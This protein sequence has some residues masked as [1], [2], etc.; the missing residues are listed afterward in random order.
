MDP[1]A[2]SSGVPFSQAKEDEPGM[3]QKSNCVVGLTQQEAA[4]FCG[5]STATIHRWVK[6][7]L[8]TVPYGQR[9]RFM[10]EDLREFMRKN[11]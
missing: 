8:K 3:C 4:A 6:A 5:V 2:K 11:P 7:G 10:V 9:K 1:A